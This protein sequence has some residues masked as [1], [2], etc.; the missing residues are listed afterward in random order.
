MIDYELHITI[1][2]VHEQIEILRDFCSRTGYKFLDLQ[3]DSGSFQRQVMMAIHFSRSNNDT[4]K[5]VSLAHIDQL[6]QMTTLLPVRVKLESRKMDDR[7]VYYEV[8]WK[9]FNFDKSLMPSLP[10]NLLISY[11]NEDSTIIYM[12]LRY[13]WYKTIPY[14]I[15]NDV[16]KLNQTLREL[17]VNFKHPHSELVL[18]D[19]NKSIDNGWKYGLA[20][21]LK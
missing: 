5:L 12:T 20:I 13:D 14:V 7:G 21:N 8:H 17:G 1:E 16:D 6:F 19:T 2:P 11:S 15:E 9:T 3:L 10:D 4:A 18:L